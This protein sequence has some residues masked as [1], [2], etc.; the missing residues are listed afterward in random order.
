[1]T[2]FPPREEQVR[3]MHALLIHQV[4][5]ACQNAEERPLL[6]QLL[7]QAEQNKWADLVDTIRSIVKGKRDTTLLKGLDEE[8]A[9]IV[10][11]ILAGLQDPTSL[12]AID[13]QADPTMAA[14]GMAR[15]IHEARRG[16]AEALQVAAFLANQMTQSQGDM[17]HM[18]GIMRKLVDGERDVEKLQDGMTER[19][20]KFVQDILDELREMEN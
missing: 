18:G 13:Q 15:V 5:K 7:S 1:M 8:D 14:P 19:G 10:R 11:S 20:Q 9:V 16:D 3:N 4:V 2:T 17:M 6:E 12:P